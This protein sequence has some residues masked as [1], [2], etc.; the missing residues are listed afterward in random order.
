MKQMSKKEFIREVFSAI[1]GAQ[2][3]NEQFISSHVS[4]DYVQHGDGQTLHYDDFVNHIRMLKERTKEIRISFKSLAE[5]NDLVFSNHT[6][7]A[8]MPDG[9]MSTLH[10]IAEFHVRNGQMCYCDELSHLENGDSAASDLG[11]IH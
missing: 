2:P 7:V 4:R 8:T 3:F 11:T 10:V 5:D 1:F 9:K 6:V